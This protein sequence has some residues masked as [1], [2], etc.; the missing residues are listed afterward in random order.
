MIRPASELVTEQDSGPQIKRERRR[1]VH[2]VVMCD[3]FNKETLFVVLTFYHSA[4]MFLVILIVK[5]I[6]MYVYMYIR[7]S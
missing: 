3:E 2:K 4:L 5:T 1:T 6:Y 7:I